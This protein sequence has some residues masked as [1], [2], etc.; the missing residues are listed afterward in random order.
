MQLDEQKTL[1][2][3]PESVCVSETAI[4][5]G[6]ALHERLSSGR[7][8][9]QRILVSPQAAFASLT[10][11][12]ALRASDSSVYDQYNSSTASH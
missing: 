9:H 4:S 7:R 3:K 5:R 6:R 12:A 2:Y 10:H 8:S 1:L 11:D